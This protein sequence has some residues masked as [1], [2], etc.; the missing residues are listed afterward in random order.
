[1]K[2]I[3]GLGLGWSSLVWSKKRIKKMLMKMILV[4]VFEMLVMIIKVLMLVLLI[5]ALILGGGKRPPFIPLLL[6]F[7]VLAN[8]GTDL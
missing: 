4:L 1:M 2:R 7:S 8:F 3:K 6:D 5:I